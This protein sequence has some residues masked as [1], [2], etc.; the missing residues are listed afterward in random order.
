MR[1]FII[2]PFGIRSGVNFDIV[3]IKLI[4]PVLVSLGIDGGTTAVF[5]DSG[6][7]HEDMFIEI[8]DADLVIADVSL[9]NANVFYELGIRHAIR[10]K[11]T[12]LI[13]TKV[14][15][16][17]TAF[18]IHGYRYTSYA[19][20]NPELAIDDLKL[21]IQSS[22][23]ADSSDSPV[24]K[25]L[26]TIAAGIKDPIQIPP[27]TLESDIRLA[28]SA[29][30]VGALRLLREDV[31]GSRWEKAVLRKIGKAQIDSQDFRGAITT[32]EEIRNSEGNTYEAQKSLGNAYSRLEKFDL[33]DEALDIALNQPAL[34]NSQMAELQSQKARNSKTKWIEQ[35]RSYEPGSSIQAERSLQSP[36]LAY[37]LRGYRR[38]A[39]ADLNSYYSWINYL[40]LLVVVQE[41]ARI[42][43]NAFDQ[44]LLFNDRNSIPFESE[45]QQATHVVVASIHAAEEK[46]NQDDALWVQ[47]SKAD[48]HLLTGAADNLVEKAYRL[49]CNQET[50]SEFHIA[51]VRRQIEIYP[52][53]GV[54]MQP[55][56][57]ALRVFPPANVKRRAVL[58]SGLMINKPGRFEAHQELTAKENIRSALI[59]LRAE[60]G[61]NIFGIAG[62]ACGGDILFHEVCFEL[63][64]PSR[65]HLCLRKDIFE[66]RSVAQGGP[67]WASRFGKIYDRAKTNSKK[68]SNALQI[69]SDVEALPTYVVNERTNFWIRANRWLMHS[70]MALSY[71]RPRILL[72]TDGKPGSPG[73]TWDF[74]GLAEEFFCTMPIKVAP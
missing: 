8:A 7:I 1:A 55:S 41:Q 13:K 57:A 21:A 39:L 4:R 6:S 5:K 66:A 3:E 52:D 16:N 60:I 42:N 69:L 65:L 37:S 56:A 46:G 35:L 48:L 14:K 17:A 68:D 22:L 70:A 50:N 45:L 10:R 47:W 30:S 24:W 34:S 33:S 71:G 36:Q 73:G 53:L 23:N 54:L 44:A 28:V 72:L 2:R 43:S 58:F 25:H 51:S 64:I 29:K 59:N 61:S 20:N 12:V 62:G 18:D 15:G 32:F 26:P 9:H 19:A 74:V 40:S 63:G 11:T 27:Q 67:S 38:A 49:A 31:S